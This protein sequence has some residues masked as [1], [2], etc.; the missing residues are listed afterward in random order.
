MNLLR[1]RG[2]MVRDDDMNIW[3]KIKTYTVP[4][5]AVKGYL[6]VIEDAEFPSN[7]SEIRLSIYCPAYEAKI[8][9]NYI[10]IDWCQ[11]AIHS[12]LTYENRYNMFYQFSDDGTTLIYLS[13]PTGQNHINDNYGTLKA[14]RRADNIVNK[15]I[16]LRCIDKPLIGAVID[17]YYR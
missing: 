7:L 10:L 17:I 3:K 2:M 8:N 4:D 6:T 5:D 9:N 11:S 14:L 16:R 15:K 12:G 1:R 13:D